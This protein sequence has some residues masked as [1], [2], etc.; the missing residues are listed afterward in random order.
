MPPSN[1][2]VL[3]QLPRTTPTQLVHIM[4]HAGTAPNVW[5]MIEDG[6][7]VTP[8][9][10][11]IMRLS[12][13]RVRWL[14]EAGAVSDSVFEWIEGF[15]KSAMLVACIWRNLKMVKLLRELGADINHAGKQ[16]DGA[17]W[18][19]MAGAARSNQ[20]DIVEYLI[21]QWADSA[22]ALAFA[23]SLSTT[24]MVD[25]IQEK[26]LA[27]IRRRQSARLIKQYLSAHVCARKRLNQRNMLRARVLRS[28]CSFQAVCSG[29]DEGVMS[30]VA[31]QLD[32]LYTEQR[33]KTDVLQS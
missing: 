4:R 2:N 8:L 24:D 11:A 1:W 31:K 28:T 17:P 32:R 19:P 23:R 10:T 18:S 27:K 33:S 25:F 21:S 16:R 26:T 3:M 6:I 30:H 15:Q 14:I 9:Y 20:M 7:F 13:K 12:Y 5:S 29:Y 22:C